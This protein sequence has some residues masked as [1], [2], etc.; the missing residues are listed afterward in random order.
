MNKSAVSL[1]NPQDF[2]ICVPTILVGE[3]SNSII[4]DLIYRYTVSLGSGTTAI[5]FT[6]EITYPSNPLLLFDYQLQPYEYPSI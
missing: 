1:R 2:D 6:L 3:E 4:R 5:A